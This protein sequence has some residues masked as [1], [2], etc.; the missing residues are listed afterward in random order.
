MT[1]KLKSIYIPALLAVI[2]SLAGFTTRFD[3]G[4]LQRVANQLQKWTD[5]YPQEKVYL[6][7]DKPYYAAGDNLWFKAYVTIGPKHQLSALSNVLNVEL[8]DSQDSV[9]KSLKLLVVNGVCTGD[10][11][12]SDSLM[13]GTY[14]LRAYTNWMRNFN[15]AYFYDEPLLIGNVIN[16]EVLATAVYSYTPQQTNVTVAYTDVNQTPYAGKPVNYTVK[17]DN[18]QVAKGKG[19]TDA[20]G[21]LTVSFPAS[22]A[23]GYRSGQLISQLKLSDGKTA[24]AALTFSPAAAQTDVQ[25]FPEGGNM[26]NGIASVVAFKAVGPN[27]LG[28]NVQGNI[29]DNNNQQVTGINT[30]HLGMGSFVLNPQ[31]GKT[32]RAVLN[33]PDGSKRTVPLPQALASGYVLSLNRTGNS[34]KLKITAS[35][36]L[37]NKGGDSEVNLVAQAGGTV[38]YAAKTNLQ[39]A[40]YTALVP[41]SR[42]PL[43][44]VQFTL[45][46][47]GSQPV[48]E[49]LIFVR[50]PADQLQMNVAS[51]Q[52]AYTARAKTS[53]RVHVQD[54]GGKPVIGSFSAA[55]IDESKV[56]VDEREEGTIQSHLLLTS[57][58]QGYVEQPGYYFNQVNEQVDAD[59]DVLMLTQGYRRFTWKPLLTDQLP[60]IAYQPEKA[61]RISGTVT[62]L[63]GKPVANG[64]VTL[65]STAGG[66]F[67]LDTVTNA[68][69]QF[70]FNN[71]I[72]KDSLR[73]I[74]QA[75]T[76]KNNRNVKV[77]MDEPAKQPV[78]A[79]KAPAG[80]LTDA[81]AGYLTYLQ[82]SKLQY[83][84]DVKYGLNG[85]AIVL[86]EVVI[87]EARTP[88]VK[89]SSNLNGAGSADQIIN[90]DLFER[91]GCVTI[92]QCL[93]GRLLGVIFRNGIP[94]STRSPNGGPMQVIVDGAY[95]SSDYLSTIN[96]YDVGSIEVLRSGGYLAIYGSQGGNGVIIV[97]TKRG[98]ES[99]NADFWAA[100]PGIITYMPKGFYIDR[101]FYKPVYA[102]P[103]ASSSIADLRTTIHWE[104]NLIPDSEGNITFNYYNADGT[105]AYRVV[106]EGISTDG[107]LGRQVYRYKAGG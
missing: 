36:D 18:H 15:D 9:K 89:H 70:A 5:N 73:F 7:L 11:A 105:G 104:K 95:V 66:A 30:R 84:N 48:A 80:L 4:F 38:L 94:Y 72:F 107:Y 39:N 86:K 10:I 57:D 100:K 102:G 21:N 2:I 41:A 12:L 76:S 37:V 98:D 71:L 106:I 19:I 93:Q 85:H 77:T 61:F 25:F 88:A 13:A 68:R 33:Y 55:V 20:R 27:G 69:G 3:D 81:P 6:H 35:A 67:V 14:R 45:F 103:K 74:V 46:A 43:G 96:P 97:N 63:G 53:I 50:N 64:K 31:S 101:E 34:I 1:A 79:G 29:V 17:L 24:G 90:G 22:E 47:P 42:F 65:F 60:A 54:A 49:R 32:Y 16:N 75:R 51:D 40:S 58:L 44:I 83:N 78:S 62:T 87:R 99:S 23:R 28:I 52:N 59:L 92:A 82:N 91:Q 8:I 56:P 26:V